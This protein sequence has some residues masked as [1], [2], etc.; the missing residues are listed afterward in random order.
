MQI[1]RNITPPRKILTKPKTKILLDER[2]HKFNFSE[3]SEIKIQKVKGILSQPKYLSQLTEIE[4]KSIQQFI[5]NNNKLFFNRKIVNS[6]LPK[7][8]LLEQKYKGIIN[9]STRIKFYNALPEK[10]KKYIVDLYKLKKLQDKFPTNNCIINGLVEIIYKSNNEEVSK[11]YS[12]I[13]KHFL[14]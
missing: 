14:L 1:K 4:H 5:L 7:F 3:V 10:E 2:T 11:L 9:H 6:L 8:I 13:N 12:K